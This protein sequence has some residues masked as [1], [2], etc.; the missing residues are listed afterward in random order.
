MK[1]EFLILTGGVLHFLILIASVQVPRLLDWKG[2][3]AKLPEHLR[4]LFWV[5][6]AFIVL[7]IVGFGALSLLFSG[8]IAAGSPLARGFAG[9][10]AVFWVARLVVQFWIFD[11]KA[12]LTRS[13]HRVGYHVLTGLFVLLVL[14]YATAA[15]KPDL[16]V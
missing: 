11:A 12:M 7:T 15:I 6:G 4:V 3:F 5:Y 16:F 8:E 13:I 9:F 2:H 14:I 10:V 1:L